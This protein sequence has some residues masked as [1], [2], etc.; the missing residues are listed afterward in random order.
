MIAYLSLQHRHRMIKRLTRQ[1]HIRCANNL[2]TF[3]IDRRWKYLIIICLF[4]IARCVS[5]TKKCF[6]PS[7]SQRQTQTEVEYIYYTHF[8][9]ERDKWAHCPYY[10]CCDLVLSSS[11]VTWLD[12]IS[13]VHINVKRKGRLHF[14]T[15]TIPTDDDERV[16][17]VPICGQQTPTLWGRNS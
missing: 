3:S 9:G 6:I 7:F 11:P 14:I 4:I 12:I 8:E 16:S 2:T 5:C 15:I 10:C 13:Q 17:L 1:L